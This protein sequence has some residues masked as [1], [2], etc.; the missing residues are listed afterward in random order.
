M[1]NSK[2]YPKPLH[3]EAMD[4]ASKANFFKRLGD[5]EAAKEHYEKAFEKEEQAVMILEDKHDCE[6]T[7]GV[8]FRSAA[9]LAINAGMYEDGREMAMKGL[10]GKQLHNEI[11][12]ELEEALAEAH[13]KLKS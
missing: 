11:K 7:R 13:E 3:N 5:Q 12:A 1:S 9:W 2:K 10:Q 4:L 6:P 8:L